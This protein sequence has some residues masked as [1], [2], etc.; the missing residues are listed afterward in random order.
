MAGLSEFYT[1]LGIHA[2]FDLG[3]LEEEFVVGGVGFA[4]S[5]LEGIDKFLGGLFVDWLPCQDGKTYC[6]GG[7][8]G[9]NGVQL[10]GVK[11]GLGFHRL[12]RL[13][14]A[15]AVGADTVLD[16]GDLLLRPTLFP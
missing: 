14:G 16:S 10:I 1:C 4:G 6:T 5:K 8:D 11:Q 2:V 12:R 15:E 7:A 3:E 13:G 9:P